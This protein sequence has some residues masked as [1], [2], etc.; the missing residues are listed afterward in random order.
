M[1]PHR[2]LLVL[3]LL[4]AAGRAAIPAATTSSASPTGTLSVWPAS[5]DDA[6]GHSIHGTRVGPPSWRMGE[7]V[8]CAMAARCM[9]QTARSVSRPKTAAVS[10]LHTQ[11]RCRS[12]RCRCVAI[13]VP[14]RTLLGSD[15]RALPPTQIGLHPLIRSVKV[16]A[17]QEAMSLPLG[18]D[19]WMV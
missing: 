2:A 1:T 12:E 16:S 8:T 15:K 6:L 11:R 10:S 3:A 7:G 4:A 14:G 9:L 19:A 18:V 5:L 13:E 17:Q